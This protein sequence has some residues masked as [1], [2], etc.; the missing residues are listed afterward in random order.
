MPMHSL[1]VDTSSV[2]N[3]RGIVDSYLNRMISDLLA[4]DDRVILASAFR[5]MKE[6]FSDNLSVKE[7]VD[8]YKYFARDF[9]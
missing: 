9:S 3:N 8:K 2:A 1:L 5:Q 4:S 6:D 7:V